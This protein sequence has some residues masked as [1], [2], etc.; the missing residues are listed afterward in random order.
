[1]ISLLLRENQRVRHSRSRCGLFQ[2]RHP[3]TEGRG[4]SWLV[5][6]CE[7][8]ARRSDAMSMTA[9]PKLGAGTRRKRHLLSLMQ[10]T[11]VEPREIPESGPEKI[12]GRPR[13]MQRLG[14]MVLPQT[15]AEGETSVA[16]REKASAIRLERLL[17]GFNSLA[18]PLALPARA[19]RDWSAMK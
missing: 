3:E 16:R 7:T 4:R 9:L 8:R 10:T 13:W 1:L 14:S 12:G 18:D 6:L 15:R 2:V 11:T 5:R 19:R 17:S